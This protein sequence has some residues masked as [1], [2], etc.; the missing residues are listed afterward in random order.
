M[1]RDLALLT[2]MF[3]YDQGSPKR[4]QHMLKVY[5]FVCYICAQEKVDASIRL[6]AETAAIVHDI[7]IR[8]SLAK[9]GRGNGYYQQIEGPARAEAMLR[10]LH[11]PEAVIQR[12][13]YLVAHHHTFTNIEGLDYQIL[14][15]ADFL[16][17]LYEKNM[18]REPIESVLHKVFRTATGK[19]LMQQMFLDPVLEI[20]TPQ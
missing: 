15:E 14:V 6:I 11:Y 17:N 10:E 12:I 16:V 9:Y 4:I 1:D 20:P 3:E 13:V 7:G 19:H 8:P 18:G 2:K 5:G